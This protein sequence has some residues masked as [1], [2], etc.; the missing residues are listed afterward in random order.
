MYLIE[1]SGA[2]DANARLTKMSVIEKTI[3]K[4]I[5]VTTVFMEGSPD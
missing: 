2:S 5:P 3:P 4:T 1:T